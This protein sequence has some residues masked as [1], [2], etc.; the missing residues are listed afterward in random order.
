VEDERPSPAA[1]NPT[2]SATSISLGFQS[3]EP[4]EL[5]AQWP[6]ECPISPLVPSQTALLESTRNP[7]LIF[8]DSATKIEAFAEHIRRVTL[9]ARQLALGLAPVAV[10]RAGL[11]GALALFKL[12]VETLKGPYWSAIIRRLVHGGLG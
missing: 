12:D 9:D 8:C 11:A 5:A 2:L 10:E 7:R 1:S 6:I 3:I 4:W